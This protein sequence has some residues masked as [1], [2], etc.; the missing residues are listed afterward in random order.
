MMKMHGIKIEE[1]ISRSMNASTQPQK[2][3]RFRL[4]QG[5]GIKRL[6]V[7]LGTRICF[8]LLFVTPL[9]GAPPLA[10]QEMRINLDQLSYKLHGQEVEINLLLERLNKLEERISH[11]SKNMPSPLEC[12]IVSLEK[13]HKA[14]IADFRSLKE[15]IHA[16]N[17]SLAKCQKKLGEIDHQL[18]SDIKALKN[19]LNSM[20]VLLGNDEESYIVKPG[21]SLGQIALD[22]KISTK[23]LKELNHLTS[24]TIIVGQKL[25][26]K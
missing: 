7:G 6:Q 25:R 13:A 5:H 23:T 1:L 24:D 21:D 11:L 10:V 26:L 9:M 15:N 14:L 22:H 3:L 20:L 18:S 17:T 8:L 19:S 12:R 16:T 2:F 4:C